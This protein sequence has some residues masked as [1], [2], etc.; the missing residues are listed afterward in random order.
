MITAVNSFTD[1]WGG[2]EFGTLMFFTTDIA[3]RGCRNY[4]AGNSSRQL[5]SPAGRKNRFFQSPS[6]RQLPLGK[7]NFSTAEVIFRGLEGLSLYLSGIWLGCGDSL[8]FHNQWKV[9]WL[10]L[11]SLGL[12]MGAKESGAEVEGVELLSPWC[13]WE[14][15]GTL[16]P[17]KLDL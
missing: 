15:E 11:P 9:P 13:C 2:P 10:C 4:Q 16:S 6:E 14:A 12:G 8:V 5:L 1:L 3:L 17:L 7:P